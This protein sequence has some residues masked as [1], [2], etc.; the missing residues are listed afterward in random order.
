MR[1]SFAS[2]SEAARHGMATGYRW[3]FGF[4]VPASL[5]HHG[6]AM[7][8]GFLVSS[9]QDM[10]QYLVAQLND[11]R[12]LEGAVLSPDGVAQLHHP[13]ASMGPQGA[14]GSAYG[15][16][17]AIASSG[18]PRIW[19]GG[20]TA[21]FHSDVALLPA[22]HLGVVVM[23]NVN[24]NLAIA[25]NA[26]GVI[27]QGVRQLLLGEQPPA[28]SGFWARYLVFDAALLLVSA[29][30]V[31]SVA[32]LLRRRTHPAGKGTLC[33]PL[34]FA[35]PL[36]WEAGL[37]LG[38]LIGFPSLAQASWPLTLL[39]FPDLGYW[40]L[41]LCGTLLATGGVRLLVILPRLHGRV[42]YATGS[43]A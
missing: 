17:W 27:A 14:R 30:A 6:G 31:W 3:W 16:G 4:P 20:D 21:N 22:R 40:L 38:L 2:E 26:E 12:Y 9:A 5:P 36:L 37:P 35:V 28:A 34:R 32:R 25:T 7:P 43:A 23:M 10:A 8:A 39:F 11:G 42:T 18:E 24:G 15:M 13:V 29:L 19:H 1:Q 41:A 33:V